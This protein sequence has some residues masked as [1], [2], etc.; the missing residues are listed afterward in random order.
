[1]TVKRLSKDTMWAGSLTVLVLLFYYFQLFQRL[2]NASV[3]LRF[4]FRGIRAPRSDIALITIDDKSLKELGLYPWPRNRHAK[5]VNKLTRAGARAVVFDVMFL[6]EDTARPDS[7]LAFGRALAESGRTVLG[8][9]IQEI[10][11]G[12]PKV[13]SEPIRALRQKGVSTGFVN[14]FPEKDGMV[15]TAALWTDHNGSTLPS[16]DLSALA[17]A[18]GMP[19]EEQQQEL[20]TVT[21][22]NWNEVTINYTGWR[23]SNSPFPYYS[24]ADVLTGRKPTSLFKDKIVII[25]GT[26]TGLFDTQAVP[27][28]RNFPGPEIHANVIDNV[29]SNSFLR[30]VPGYWT[31]LLILVLGLSGGRLIARSRAWRGAT[32]AITWVVVYFIACQVFFNRANLVMDYVAPTLAL[33]TVYLAMSFRRLL[34]EE[35]EKR[36]IKSTFGQYLSPKV[37]DIL[38]RDPSRLKLG[39][40]ERE[41]TIFFS[42]I[43][44]FTTLAERMTPQELV[45][46]LNE[47]LTVM[48]DIILKHD[49]VLDKYIGDAIMA[50]WN[51]PVDQPRH[52]A[53]ACLAAVEQ[54]AALE[55]VRK[56]FA[57]KNWP[58]IDCRMGLNTGRAIIGNM[59]SHTR[60]DYTV[61]GD[62]VNLASRLES[63]N[64]MFGTRAMISEFTQKIVGDEFAVRELDFL[65]VKG[66]T[67]PIRVY[68]LVSETAKLTPDVVGALRDFREGLA[69]YRDRAFVKAQGKFNA[70][71]GAYAEDHPSKIYIKRCEEFLHVPPP[72]DWDGVYVMTSK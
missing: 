16:L 70:V 5:L 31:F 21:V 10:S 13:I 36:R 1:M 63:A 30:Q 8:S 25:C 4:T 9:L 34:S 42:D 65:R 69:F 48:T 53:L 47:Y 17:V 50:F 18:R 40:E 7:D 35:F 62:T 49:G 67:Q 24:Y 33:L 39:G 27:N 41:M 57:D 37:I 26:A 68:E 64:K 23:G 22:G 20:A 28:L 45:T 12:Q 2:E 58:P 44:G 56:Q 29:L 11:G 54:R 3:D 72:K 14:V 66:K 46:A 61:M 59:G 15:R 43:A 60:F 6:E 52:A 38:I 55:L 71:L 32:M 51:A 19:L